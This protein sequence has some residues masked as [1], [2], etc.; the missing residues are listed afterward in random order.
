MKKGG[1]EYF[2]EVN[3]WNTE[4]YELFNLLLSKEIPIKRMTMAATP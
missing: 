3:Y 1:Q 2:M 4:D